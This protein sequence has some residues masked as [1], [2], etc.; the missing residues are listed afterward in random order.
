MGAPIQRE[1]RMP[2]EQC[3]G[4]RHL[5]WE[6]VRVGVHIEGLEDDYSFTCAAFPKGIP[7]AITSR[8][9]DH[10]LPFRGDKGIRFEPREENQAAGRG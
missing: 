9:R 10:R 8:R 2:G 5:S 4:C 6:M 3:C 1:L 7:E